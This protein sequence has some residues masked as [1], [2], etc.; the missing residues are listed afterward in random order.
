MLLLA[1]S[2]S[3]CSKSNNLLIGRVETVL[4]THAVVVTDCYRTSVPSPQASR[5]S[6]DGSPI[7]RFMPCKDADVIIRNE[8]LIVNGLRYESLSPGDTVI[9]D[10]GQVLVNTHIA[11]RAP[12]PDAQSG[13]RLHK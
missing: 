7:Y 4:G 2:V 5:D 12:E 10:H 8:H 3:A 11:R 1:L 9:V 13:S 6:V